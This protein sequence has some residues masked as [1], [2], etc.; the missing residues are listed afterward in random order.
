MKDSVV[1]VEPADGWDNYGTYIANNIDIP[2]DNLKKIMH[3][4]VLVSF[5]V[6]PNGAI[7]NV[8]VDDSNCNNC[9]EVA[10]RVIEQG[11]QWK[12]KKG[13]KASARIMLQF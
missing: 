11:P 10:K 4:E 13:R 7:T 8:K 9:G 12:V 3:G 5:D 1:N 2:D 6:K